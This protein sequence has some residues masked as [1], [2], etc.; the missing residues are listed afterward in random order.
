M[1]AQTAHS[2]TERLLLRRPRL[3][4]AAAILRFFGDADAMRYTFKLADLRACRRHIA[5][6]Q[7]QR[8][9]TGY[10]P[11]TLVEKA[12]GEVI[13]FGG[14]YDD[15]FDP[16]W[17]I[18][19]GYHFLPSA[20]GKGYASELTSHCVRYARDQL[21]VRAISAFAHRDNA[22]SR[23]VLTKA[24]FDEVRF[25]AGMDRYLYVHTLANRG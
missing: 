24:G 13:G 6:H 16:G 21:G 7:C 20:W 11:W 4:D 14:L 19:V 18:E 2:E 8:R 5:G 3:A 17:G 9:K 15:P 1:S 25:V 23:R 10:G 12:R 22:A